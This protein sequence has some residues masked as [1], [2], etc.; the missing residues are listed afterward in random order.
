MHDYKVWITKDEEKHRIIYN[1][2]LAMLDFPNEHLSGGQV[3][4]DCRIP[5]LYHGDNWFCLIENYNGT[6]KYQLVVM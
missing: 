6:G 1:A 3:L 5:A 2:L 4:E